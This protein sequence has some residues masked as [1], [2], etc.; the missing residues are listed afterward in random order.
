MKLPVNQDIAMG[1]AQN[2]FN[3]TDS[4]GGTECG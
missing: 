4:V 1:S 3:S 2:E